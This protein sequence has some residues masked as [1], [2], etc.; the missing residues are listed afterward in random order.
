MKI[1]EILISWDIFAAVIVGGALALLLPPYLM[2][3]LIKDLYGVGITVLSIIFTIYFAALAIIISSASDDFILFL[4]EEGDY[5]ALLAHFR[6]AVVVTFIA[7]VASIVFYGVTAF[8]L[9][10]NPDAMQT[11]WWFVCY[12]ILFSYT[13]GV[14]FNTALD[15]LQYPRFRAQHLQVTHEDRPRRRKPK[16][17]KSPH[18]SSSD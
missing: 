4:E 16:N 3:V 11:R 5:T 13:L 2:A 17:S 14:V 12:V 1:K 10:A 7:L 15:A 8:Q 18:K 9:T 6:Y